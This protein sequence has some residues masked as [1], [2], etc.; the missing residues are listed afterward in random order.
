MDRA[1]N[2]VYLCDFDLKKNTGKDRATRQKLSA[3]RGLVNDLVVVSNPFKSQFF[4]IL[5][6]FILDI[7]VS[8]LLLSRRPDVFISRGYSGW[9]SMLTAKALSIKTAREIHADAIEELSLLPYRGVKLRALGLL[10]KHAHRMDLS[11]DVRIFN[12]PD[13]ME[14]YRKRGIIGEQ[15]FFTYNGYAPGERSY[16]SRA[17]AR[18]KFGLSQDDRIVVFVG[19]A[20]KWHGVE[21]LVELQREFD[22]R[23]ENIKVVVGGGDITEFDKEGRCINFTPLGDQGCAELIRA[24]DFCL[25]PVKQNRLSPGSPLKLYDYIAN[26]RFVFAQKETNG[27]SDEVEKLNIGMPVDFTNPS[28]AS[29]QIIDAFRESCWPE[30]YPNCKASW[31]DRM[32]H[33]VSGLRSKCQ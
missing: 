14:G 7:K 23:G 26:E 22:Q 15:D 4:R 21:Y 31:A 12:H 24:A 32:A 28:E 25:L 5:A 6:I 33:W 2:V 27:Y 10:A 13:L 9:F 30:D 18:E 19:A 3:L 8:A 16:F 11:A 17:K 29:L 1:L 20:S